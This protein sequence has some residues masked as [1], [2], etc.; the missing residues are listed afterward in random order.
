M[1]PRMGQKWGRETSL[2]PGDMTQGDK[3]ELGR[4]PSLPRDMQSQGSGRGSPDALDHQ[5]LL[6]GAHLH[7]EQRADLAQALKQAHGV[8]HGGR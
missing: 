6:L 4:R 2:Y 8:R 7:D 5:V 3:L 1:T